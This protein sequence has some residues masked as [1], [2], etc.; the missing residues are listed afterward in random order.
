MATQF[1]AASVSACDTSSCTGFI[2]GAWTAER[3]KHA[4]WL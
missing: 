1:F 2:H 4:G 3:Q